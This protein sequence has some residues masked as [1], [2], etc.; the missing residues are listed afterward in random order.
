MTQR[1][2]APKPVA[3]G[4]VADRIF[5]DLKNQ[6]ITGTYAHGSKLP[7][8]K[9]LAE[10]YAVSGP[11]LREAVRGL[12][13]IGLVEVRHGSGAYV[14]ADGEALVAMSLSAFIQLER[15]GASDA[16]SILGVLNAHAATCAVHYATPAE[17]RRL[18]EA[19]DALNGIQ[20]IERAVAGVRAFHRAFGACSHNPLLA[21]ICYFLSDIQVEFATRIAG[22][23]LDVWRSMI[24]GLQGL[25]MRIVDAIEKNQP[26]E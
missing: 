4:R 13:A 11:T 23:S 3:K 8:E 12:T 25:R 14:R 10:H 18:R 26:A 22:D 7:T 17:L 19:A 20:R 6:I 2:K 5:L 24:T 15:V 21:S 9:E 1:K 16:L